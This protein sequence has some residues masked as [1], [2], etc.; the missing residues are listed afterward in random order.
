M[1]KIINYIFIIAGALLLIVS[2]NALS[3][4]F[5]ILG[6]GIGSGSNLVM[7]RNMTTSYMVINIIT[8]LGL[9]FYVSTLKRF[10]A[11]LRFW[12]SLVIFVPMIVISTL[13][14]IFLNL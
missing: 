6:G 1:S 2:S 14:A 8:I 11:S 7:I 5:K 13:L 4:L 3:D 12:L 9:G 10:N